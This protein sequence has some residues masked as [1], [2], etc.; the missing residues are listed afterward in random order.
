MAGGKPGLTWNYREQIQL[1]VRAG[2][3]FGH[4]NCKSG[5]L[6]A[7]LGFLLLENDEG[8]LSQVLSVTNLEI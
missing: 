3:A 1:A 4:L 2:L 5:A 6:T 8:L 7:R